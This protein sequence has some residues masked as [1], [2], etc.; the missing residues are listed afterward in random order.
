MMLRSVARAR[1][2]AL[3]GALS[4][5]LLM[6]VQPIAASAAAVTPA[7]GSGVVAGT[8][9]PNGCNTS[10]GGFG[11]GQAKALGS[12]FAPVAY[13]SVFL[14]GQACGAK[15]GIA[16]VGVVVGV[17]VPFVTAVGQSLECQ[18]VGTYSFKKAVLTVTAGR[19][20]CV[21]LNGSSQVYTGATAAAVTAVIAGPVMVGAFVLS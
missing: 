20:P 9:G 21:V 16:Y 1:R 2:L 3:A 10:A 14:V 8:S 15:T 4:A 13:M 12:R 17:V 19:Q 5:G 18:L 11:I 6:V 7:K